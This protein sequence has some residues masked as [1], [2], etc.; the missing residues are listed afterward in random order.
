MIEAVMVIFDVILEFNV[1]NGERIRY[2]LIPLLSFWR[3]HCIVSMSFLRNDFND[4]LMF[5]LFS[6][7]TIYFCRSM[8]LAQTKWNALFLQSFSIFVLHFISSHSIVLGL[9]V[10]TSWAFLSLSSFFQFRQFSNKMHYLVSFS[11]FSM[12]FKCV[13]LWLFDRLCRHHFPSS[14]LHSILNFSLYILF[15][16]F[17][18]SSFSLVHASMT[19]TAMSKV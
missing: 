14:F 4:I 5:F 18:F 9:F 13:C 10:S 2:E 7:I 11:S 16:N 6:S 17:E 15:L 1:N 8:V 19:S 3:L 12:F